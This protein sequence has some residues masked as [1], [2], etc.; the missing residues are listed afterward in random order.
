MVPAGLHMS[1][2]EQEEALVFSKSEVGFILPS[3]SPH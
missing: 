2:E 3:S 1:L